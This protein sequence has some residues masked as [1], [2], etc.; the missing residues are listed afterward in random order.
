[1]LCRLRFQGSHS[2]LVDKKKLGTDLLV[3]GDL[4]SDENNSGIRGSPKDNKAVGQ[5]SMQPDVGQLA[6]SLESY[7]QEIQLQMNM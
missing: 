2:F 6:T 4:D 5:F 3:T 1:M 7:A